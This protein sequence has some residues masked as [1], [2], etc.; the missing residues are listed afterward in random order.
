MEK[1]KT[2]FGRQLLNRKERD[3]RMIDESLLGVAD[4]L[5][6][7]TRYHYHEYDSVKYEHEL[8]QICAYFKVNIPDDIRSSNDI[9]ETIEFVTRPIGMMHR[10]V[11]L[12]GNWWKDGDGPLLA[13]FKD[14][15]TPV[16]LIPGALSSYYYED[17]NGNKVRITKKNYDSFER[18]AVCFYAPLPQRELGNWELIFILIRSINKIDIGRLIISTLFITLVGVVVPFATNI[19]FSTI[20]PTGLLLLVYSILILLLASAIST[21]IISIV[22]TSLLGRI[23]QRMEVFLEN[24]IMGRL[25]SLPAKFFQEYSSGGLSQSVLSLNYLPTIITDAVLGPAMT[26]IFSIVYLVQISLLAPSL[27]IPAFAI[28]FVEGLILSISIRQKI[29][30]VQAELQGD[31]ATHGMV[32]PIITGIQRIR[33]SGSENRVM[34]RWADVYKKKSGASFRV[35]FPATFQN[36]LITAVTLLGTLWVY[37]IGVDAGIS[38]AQFAAFQAAFGVVTAALMQFSATGIMLAY[39]KPT[40]NMIKPVVKCVPEVNG[41]K[42]MVSRLKGGIELN[43]VSFRYTEEQ[44]LILNDINLK[45][46]PGEY[47]AIVGKS[48]C[49]KSTI[50]RLLMGFEKPLSGTISYDDISIENID[51]RSLRSNI[52]TVLQNGKLFVGD[53]FSNI[54]ISAPY[55]TLKDAWDAAEKAG[56]AETIRQMPMQ[57][58]TLISEGAGGIS[59]GQKQRLLIARAIAP[60][61]KILILDEATSALDNI[62]QKIVSDSLD[63]LNCTRIVVAHRLSTIKNCDRIIV[64]DKGKIIEDG[65]YDELIDRKGFFCDLVSRQQLD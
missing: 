10:R 28:F 44:P 6:G 29:K 8:R 14:T 52:G 41:S 4:S 35:A 51:P 31:I 40:L 19:I 26:T 33:L 49:G 1:K 54:T 11:M 3:S 21:Y 24:A 55:L 16:A 15:G 27:S 20:I 43:G 22:R 39:L 17:V 30:L 65:T 13:V 7:Q 53:I 12:D 34:A 23:R 5:R 56:V 48:G 32:F 47:V 18:E 62:T 61:P 9:N 46:K 58:N 60:K 63:A 50:I 38:V 42:E 45:I 2:V 25:I 37:K 64:L 59:G 36:E 57:M